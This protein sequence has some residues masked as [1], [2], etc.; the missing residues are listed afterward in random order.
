M[1]LSLK[2]A[3]R[4]SK[5]SR[6]QVEEVLSELKS[7]HPDIIFEPFFVKTTGDLD[8]KTSLR[9]M[10]KTDFFT[11]E[12]DQLLLEKKCRI[13]IHAAKDLPDPIPHGLALVAL[14][15]GVATHDVLVMREKQNLSDLPESVRIGTSSLRREEAIKA[16]CPN[17]KLVDIRGTI[18]K[19]LEQ[20]DRGDVDGIVMAEAALLRLGLNRNR[21]KLTTN[22]AP[23]QGR[24]AVI[25]RAGDQ[26]MKHLFACIDCGGDDEVSTLS[27]DRSE[28]V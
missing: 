20:L 17:V 19:R 5:L 25:A 10:D 7:H 18:E 2:V 8:L 28:R 13:A 3:A 14:T 9:L 15:K 21:L 27:W 1:S 24:L 4:S 26:E 6:I 16:L 11:R 23:L 12:I 22:V